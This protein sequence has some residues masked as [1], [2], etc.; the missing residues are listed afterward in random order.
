MACEE[1]K[2]KI[3]FS[4]ILHFRNERESETSWLSRRLLGLLLGTKG[5]IGEFDRRRFW[6]T[7][8]D[9]STGS[10][11][12]SLFKRLDA[13]KSVSLSVL[14]LT[15]KI[16]SNICWKS[17]LKSVKSPFRRRC[18]KRDRNENVKK[19][20]VCT[21]LCRFCTTKKWRGL[22][23]SCFCPR[24]TKRSLLLGGGGGDRCVT[25]QKQLRGRLVGK[26]LPS[27]SKSQAFPRS[28]LPL[29]DQSS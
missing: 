14:T 1:I 25:R 15:E 5:K 16:C 28:N 21:F 9:R 12:F 18:F 19:Q 22:P 10:E 11:P 26:R 3:I 24:V 8:V 2:V 27:L 20:Q 29:T 6:A 13:T 4:S 23:G 7:H 17:W